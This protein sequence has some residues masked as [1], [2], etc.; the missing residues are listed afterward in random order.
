M[1]RFLAL[2]DLD[3][4][5]VDSAPDI[6][7][8]LDSALISSSLPAIGEEATRSYIGDGSKRLVHRAITRV[9][10]GV[11][12]MN[13]Y[14]EVFREFEN[15]YI[16]NIFNKSKLYPKVLDTLRELQNYQIYLGCVTN[17]PYNYTIPL[18]QEAGLFNYFQII[19]G[20]DS[21]RHKKPNPEPIRH[22][23]EKVGAQKATTSMIGDSITD[24][25]AAKNASVKAICVSYGYSGGI[26]LLEH[27]PDKMIGSMEELPRAILS[28]FPSLDK[29]RHY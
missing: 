4:T 5:L 25:H 3:G 12:D 24:L 1:S 16:K 10:E 29:N 20:G 19:L 15:N 11:A 6:S 26:D 28:L 23:I 14:A 8:A 7:K 17:K 13:L 2:F 18:L 27:K 21:L 22:A 9:R